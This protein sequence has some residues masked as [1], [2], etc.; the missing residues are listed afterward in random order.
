V[1]EF[2]YRIGW[3]GRGIR[4][5]AHRSRVRGAGEVFREYVPLQQYPDPRRLDLRAMARDPMEGVHVRI[6]ER[7]TAIRVYLIADMSRSMQFPALQRS[8]S[9]GLLDLARS[10]AASAS[11]AG[12]RF[13]LIACATAGGKPVMGPVQRSRAA[14]FDLISRLHQLPPGANAAD[15]LEAVHTLPR[16][17]SLVFLA[18]DFFWDPVLLDRVLDG[19]SGHDCIPVWLR[20]PQA[21]QWLPRWG[22]CRVRDLES[23]R[24]RLFFLRPGLRDRIAKAASAQQTIIEQVFSR[25][26]RTPC[27]MQDGFSC[28]QLTRY[29]DRS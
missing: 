13:G 23:G 27:V 6:F 2:Q 28:D 5:G 15:V 19:L 22:L 11:S 16:E 20:A 17:Q 21:W 14:S 1:P 29:F 24:S 8:S 3:A 4:P 25:H 7:R 18:S 9:S 12:D 26:G 10:I